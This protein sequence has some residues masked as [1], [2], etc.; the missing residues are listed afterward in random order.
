MSYLVL[1]R[2]WRPQRF[3]DV[4]G[5]EHVTQTLINAIEQDRVAHAFVFTGSRG[6]GK[7]STARILAKALNCEH[8]PTPTPCNECSSC[9]E[10]TDGSA[11]DV[12]EI[13]GASN[14]GIGEIRELREAVRYAPSRGR[15]KIYIIDEVHM[16][17]TEAFNALLKTLEEPPKHALFVF[18]TTEPRKIPVTILSRCQR[19]DFKRVALRAIVGRLKRICDA[20]GLEYEESALT[21]IGRQARGG[22]RDALSALDQVIAFTDAKISAISTAEVLGVASRE[23]FLRIGHAILRRDAGELLT[24]LEEIDSYGHDL[25]QFST[26]LLR[27][28]RDM[29]V[30]VAVGD[31]TALIELSQGELDELRRQ[32][33]GVPVAHVER[34]FRVFSRAVEQLHHSAHPKLLLEM[35][36][37]RLT[38]VEPLVPVEPLVRKLQALESALSADRE[39]SQQ[40]F[41]RYHETFEGIPPTIRTPSGRY[42]AATSGRAVTSID[43]GDAPPGQSLGSVSKRSRGELTPPSTPRE[44]VSRAK[45]VQESPRQIESSLAGAKS[46]ASP[47]KSDAKATA[48]PMKSDAKATAPPMKSDAKATAP[49]MKSDTKVT[50][51]PVKSDA[52]TTAPPVKSNTPSTGPSPLEPGD[53]GGRVKNAAS[54]AQTNSTSPP[55]AGSKTRTA[56]AKRSPERGQ[57]GQSEAFAAVDTS[58]HLDGSDREQQRWFQVVEGVRR[59]NPLLASKFERMVLVSFDEA[60]LEFWLPDQYGGLVDAQDRAQLEEHVAHH[61]GQKPLIKIFSSALPPKNQRRSLAELRTAAYTHQLEQQRHRIATD[62]LLAA[63]IRRFGVGEEQISIQVTSNEGER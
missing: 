11:V 7:T 62:T 3:E 4:V 27:H 46:D 24:L 6:V 20:E 49:P 48:P 22:M 18:A 9:L 58:I 33:E 19:Y 10:I 26:T 59:K 56:P 41:E 15:R 39:I 57:R 47:V 44:E 53:A 51:P 8:G 38:S 28:L 32:L 14:R 2:K 5:Q 54:V 35:A 43:P 60:S 61:V 34:L 12:L 17:T 42:E 13:D 21:L 63:A 52:K 1:A 16:L 31:P 40:V 29:A 30:V 45:T 36:L 50:A 37:I 55:P 25:V 23:H